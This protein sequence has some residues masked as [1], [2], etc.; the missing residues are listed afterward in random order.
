MR[1]STARKNLVEHVRGELA[2]KQAAEVERH[3]SDCLECREECEILKEVFRAMPV[4]S[5]SFSDRPPADY[6]KTFARRVDARLADK[7]RKPAPIR[8]N[9]DG[10]GAYLRPRWKPVLVSAGVG[11]LMTA[12]IAIW[13]LGPREHPPVVPGAQDAQV[14]QATH[15]EEIND[16][17][18]RSRI[19]LI[20]IANLPADDGDKIDFSVERSAARDL[21]HTARYLEQKPI[22][23]RSRELIRQLERVLVELANLEAQTDVPEVDVIRT[24]LRQQNLLFKIR[25]AENQKR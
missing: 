19:L 4:A 20:G 23:S 22:D 21:V 18:E 11:A 7:G 16:Y 2:A 3:V 25:M 14:I 15:R 5:G 1:H 12:A 10:I 6:W 24:G 8:L 13:L 17:F 9:L